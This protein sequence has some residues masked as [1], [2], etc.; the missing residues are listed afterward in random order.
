M[1]RPKSKNRPAD[2]NRP[3]RGKGLTITNRRGVLRGAIFCAAVLLAFVVSTGA[4]R[5]DARAKSSHAAPS[6]PAA[7]TTQPAR[8][9]AVTFD[10]LPMTG[11][12]GRSSGEQVLENLK[13]IAATLKANGVPAIGFVNEGKLNAPGQRAARTEALRAWLDAGFDLGNHTFSHKSF[14]NTPLAAF[15]REVTDGEPVTRRLLA[16]RGKT[17]RYFRHP[18][19]NTGRTLAEKRAFEKFLVARGYRVAPV[20][21]DNSEWVFAQAYSDAIRDGDEEKRRRLVAE[22]TPYMETMFE[23]YERLS[24]D[25]FKRE[26]PQVLLVHANQLNGDHFAEIV[27]MLKARGYSFVSLGEALADPAYRSRDDYV[28]DV[29]VSWLQRWLVTRGQAF[30]PEPPLPEYTRRFD[31]DIRGASFKTRAAR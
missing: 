26:I 24:R 14:Y 5:R 12:G 17:L 13:K 8:R 18:F 28:G 3:A 25:L 27:S 29:G 1:N 15:K 16:E 2:T 19:L 22:Y 21:V 20:T 10:D 4:Q 11:D 23:F 6:Q 9:V 31:A 30:R 7:E